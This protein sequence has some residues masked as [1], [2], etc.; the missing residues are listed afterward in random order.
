MKNTILTITIKGVLV[1]D[2]SPRIKGYTKVVSND[3]C[4]PQNLFLDKKFLGS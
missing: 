4:N 3:D 1:Y 2:I